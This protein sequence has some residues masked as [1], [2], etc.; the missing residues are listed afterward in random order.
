M[1]ISRL[2]A[3][4]GIGKTTM[5]RNVV[6]KLEEKGIK[7]QGFYTQELREGRTRVGFDIVTLDG[8]IAP[9]SRVQ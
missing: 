2:V 9:L 6:K 1:F 5:V 7:C 4:P 3:F 8:K